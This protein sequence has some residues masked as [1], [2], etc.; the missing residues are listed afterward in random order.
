LNAGATV[1]AYHVHGLRTLDYRQITE[2]NVSN[3]NLVRQ[4]I[5]L[6]GVSVEYK[7]CSSVFRENLMMIDSRFPEIFGIALLHAYVV[8]GGKL[9][10][11]FM[12]N[13][14]VAEV[15][16]GFVFSDV[17]RFISHKA[18]EFLKQVSLG[19]QPDTPWNGSNE[20]NGGA[21]IVRQ[22]GEVVC[23]SLEHE[24]DYKDFLFANTKFD[25]PSSSKHTVGRV[26]K[27]GD[28]YVLRLSSQIRMI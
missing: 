22:N 19:M 11:V 26:V 9:A 6:P 20:V 10:N 14:V 13:R 3:K 2:R 16:K 24:N 8:K 21:L 23:L 18:K 7:D 5:E 4:L 28:I 17:P 25:T 1:F 12:N 15:S 27:E